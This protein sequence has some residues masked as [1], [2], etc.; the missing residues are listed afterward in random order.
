MSGDEFL[1]TLVSVAFGPVAWMWWIARASTI[2][3][4]RAGRNFVLKLA[5]VIVL[6]VILIERTL[7]WGAADDV[8]DA[9]QYMLMYALLGWAWLWV[10]GRGFSMLG[11]SARDDL[12]ERR[13]AAAVPA[14]VGAMIGVTFCYAGGNI[15]NGPGW[16]VVVFSAALATAGLGA[17]W[18]VLGEKLR[19]MDAVTIDR[20]PAAGWRLGGFLAAAGVIC[21][22]GVTGDWVNVP[23]TVVE[24]VARIWPLF[25]IGIVAA[26]IERAARPTP[27][28]PRANLMAAGVVPAFLYVTTAVVVV[29][30][31]WPTP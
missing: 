9:P 13:N 4:F 8:R 26:L 25:P 30:L 15:G 22:F 27:Q 24:F 20:D 19:V 10:A 17:A 21:G 14:W 2:A 31:S 6:C 28:R 23:A 29:V 11:L 16:W 18:F 1:V 3:G 12:L 5:G 7:R